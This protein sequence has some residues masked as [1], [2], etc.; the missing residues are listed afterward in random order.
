MPVGFIRRLARQS[1]FVDYDPGPPQVG[2]QPAVLTDNWTT[3]ETTTYDASMPADGPA[4]YGG[5]VANLDRVLTATGS[6]YTVLGLLLTFVNK[7]P[8][9]Q[10]GQTGSFGGV[11]V[12]VT[13]TFT[14]GST[15]ALEVWSRAGATWTKRRRIPLA[16]L[17]RS[18]ET[19]VIDALGPVL[20]TTDVDAYWI[21]LAPDLGTETITWLACHVYGICLNDPVTPD[22]PPGAPPEECDGPECGVDYESWVCEEP[23]EEPVPTPDPFVFPPILVQVANPTTYTQQPPNA[24]FAGKFSHPCPRP[25]R[26]FMEFGELPSGGSVTVTL[27]PGQPVSFVEGSSQTISAPGTMTWT[28]LTGISPVN[29]PS[30]VGL[31][32]AQLYPTTDFFFT[33]QLDGSVFAVAGNLLDILTYFWTAFIGYEEVC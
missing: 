7:P 11:Y 30:S 9:N 27:K 32:P 1:L 33:R 2:S 12:K 28:V 10:F 29:A 23:P 20:S 25:N 6:G 15:A 4:P 31:F 19:V 14:T 24:P 3:E 26:I 17:V 13:P 22:C 21:T 8:G 5:T 16:G 18:G